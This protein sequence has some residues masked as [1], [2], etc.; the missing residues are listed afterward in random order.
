MRADQSD[1]TLNAGPG[2]HD[3][4]RSLMAVLL[5]LRVLARVYTEKALLEG[6][7]APVPALLELDGS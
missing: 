3:L 7:L 6:A 4:A 1:G 5:G 2:A